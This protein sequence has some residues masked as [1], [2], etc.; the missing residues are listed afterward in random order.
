MPARR[1]TLR[2]TLAA[3]LGVVAG[4]VAV[5]AAAT[6]LTLANH[7]G[8]ASF[9]VRGLV[10]TAEG[11]PIGGAEVGFLA[12][13]QSAGYSGADPH[14]AVGAFPIPGHL[15]EPST[16]TIDVPVVQTNTAGVYDVI[17]YATS[18]QGCVDTASHLIPQD[19]WVIKGGFQFHRAK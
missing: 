6:G 3:V 7:Q 19:L 2:G 17:V 10:K 18:N 5:G 11:A 14:F 8:M 4:V 12:G 16:C 15:G 13:S 9:H 1:S